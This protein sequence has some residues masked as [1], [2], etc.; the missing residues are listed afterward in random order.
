MDAVAAELMVRD[1]S[2]S[3]ITTAAGGREPQN[4]CVE[5]VLR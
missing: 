2:P 5:I 1:I 4:R 3:K